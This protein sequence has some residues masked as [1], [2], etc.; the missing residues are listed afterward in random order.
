M[1]TFDDYLK[2]NSSPPSPETTIPAS[3]AERLKAVRL[4]PAESP[5]PH[6]I[7]ATADQLLSN[8]VEVHRITMNDPGATRSEKRVS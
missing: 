7:G 5:Q 2:A 8:V 3:I 1:M 4:L 6:A